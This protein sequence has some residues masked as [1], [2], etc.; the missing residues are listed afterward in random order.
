MYHYS[1]F[2]L[3]IV[4]DLLLQTVN[5]IEPT[6]A[7]DVSIRAGLIDITLP[8]NPAHLCITI[9]NVAQIVVEHGS[10][11]TY[12][13]APSCDPDNLRL[14]ILGSAMGAILQ[15]R[16]LI[17]LHANAVSQ[18]GSNA[19]LFIGDSGA[20][21]STL[22]AWHYQQKSYLLA[23]DVCAIYFDEHGIPRVLPSYP[24]IKL[25]QASADLLGITTNNLA[26][27]R[28]Q[29]AKY[30]LAIHEQFLNKALPVTKILEI[31][32]DAKNAEFSGLTKLTLLQR[33]SYRPHFLKRMRLT[34]S[35]G[36]LLVRL[37]SVVMMGS[38]ARLKL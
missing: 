4:S 28:A 21:K 11:I 7:I 19:T 2:G 10:R 31:H 17:V 25:W 1:A 3:H 14:F 22:A 35:Y 29:D 32:R 38:Q 37:A 20:G 13:P 15:Q 23:D 33:H 36:A 27:I 30:A 34:Q 5:T 12:Q 24:H 18:N 8:E 16:G 6:I 26:K 9:P